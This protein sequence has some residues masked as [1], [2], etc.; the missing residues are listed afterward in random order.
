M[1]P[2]LKKPAASPSLGPAALRRA[3]ETIATAVDQAFD[4]RGDVTLYL[5]SGEQIEGYVYNRD[6]QASVPFL[7]IF[8][9]GNGTSRRFTY[10]EVERIEHTGTDTAAGR[11]WEAWQE[12][13]A[14]A[15]RNGTFAELYPES[16]DD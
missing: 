4:Y 9:K 8:P 3:A 14:E 15:E 5:T 13:V 12:K 16:L 1:R 6:A 11:S 10:D 2:V 7:E